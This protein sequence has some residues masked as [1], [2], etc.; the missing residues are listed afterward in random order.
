MILRTRPP[1]L[2]NMATTTCK[3]AAEPVLPLVRTVPENVQSRETPSVY[4]DSHAGTIP[5]PPLRHAHDAAAARGDSGGPAAGVPGEVDGGVTA[6]RGGRG[7][8]PGRS[9]RSLRNGRSCFALHGR[10]LGG[11]AAPEGRHPQRYKDR[12]RVP[13]NLMK[14]ERQAEPV[15]QRAGRRGCGR[16]PKVG[17]AHVPGDAGPDPA[18]LL[19]LAPLLYR[20]ASGVCGFTVLGATGP[21]EDGSARCATGVDSSVVRKKPR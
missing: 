1:F 6:A 9:G 8:N 12:P 17:R 10:G 2:C 15:V 19:G 20:F 3:P 18:G 16:S 7:T 5:A 21:A 13:K 4:T 11:A 14:E